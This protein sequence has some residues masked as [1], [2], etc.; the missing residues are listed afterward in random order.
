VSDAEIIERL[1]GTALYAV[2]RATLAKPYQPLGYILQPGEALPVPTISE[3]ASRWPGMAPEQ[4]EEIQKDYTLE[5]D[6]LG[7]LELEDVYERVREL[8]VAS[9]DT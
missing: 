1:Q 3:L 2:L 9:L 7:D 6:N 8:A 5:S 4:L